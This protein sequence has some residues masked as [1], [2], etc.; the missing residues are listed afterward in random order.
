[1]Q[2]VGWIFKSP[3]CRGKPEENGISFQK[4]SD[5]GKPI[6]QPRSTIINLTDLLFFF[7][8]TNT[9]NKSTNIIHNLLVILENVTFFQ[10]IL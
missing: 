4:K 5:L 3:E 6:T 1:L 8:L 7:A 10:L 9:I 2:E